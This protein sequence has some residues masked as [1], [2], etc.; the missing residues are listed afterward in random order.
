MANEVNDNDEAASREHQMSP[1]NEQSRILTAS[2]SVNRYYDNVS[3]RPYIIVEGTTQQQ[4]H[5]HTYNIH[6]LF[7]CVYVLIL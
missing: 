5:T 3:P 7:V 4:L 1:D 2:P 6:I